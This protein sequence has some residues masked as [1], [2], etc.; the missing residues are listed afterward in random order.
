MSAGKATNCSGLSYNFITMDSGSCHSSSLIC[1][2]MRAPRR[3]A[4]QVEAKKDG[5][6]D[7]AVTGKEV[8][9]EAVVAGT[10]T[11]NGKTKV[12]ATTIGH[13]NATV[14]D[15]RYLDLAPRGL[16]WHLDKLAAENLKTAE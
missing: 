4:T 1:K 7:K 14:D 2:N 5:K 8:T 15:P 12:F 16:I 13:N 9:A 11:Y 3:E 6:D 10:N